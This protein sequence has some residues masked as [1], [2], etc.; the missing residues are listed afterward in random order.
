MVS[1]LVIYMRCNLRIH[2]G[3]FFFLGKPLD[4]LAK[5]SNNRLIGFRLSFMF[6]QGIPYLCFIFPTNLYIT[7]IKESK[8][9]DGCILGS[10]LMKNLRKVLIW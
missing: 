2:D 6:I 9:N 5:K 1:V 10:D 4:N 7:Y 3:T 8:V